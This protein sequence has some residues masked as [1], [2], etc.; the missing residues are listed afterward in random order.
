[1]RRLGAIN[2]FWWFAGLTIFVTLAV[3][4]GLAVLLW[5]EIDTHQKTVILQI[6]KAYFAYIFIAAFFFAAALFI[7]LD[8]FFH[9]YIIPLNKITEQTAIIATVNPS[10]R[11]KL[12]G[13]RDIQRLAEIINLGAERF[14]AMGR[15]TTSRIES[16]KA[17][18]EAEKNILAGFISELPQGVLVCNRKGRILLYNRQARN[19]LMGVDRKK[20]RGSGIDDIPPSKTAGF[21]G[22][23]RSITDILDRNMLAHAQEVL[24]QKLAEPDTPSVTHFLVA[25]QGGMFL[26]AEMAPILDEDEHLNGFILV[27][28]NISAQLE[29]KRQAA[30]Q[31]QKFNTLMRASLAGIRS[32]IET[33]IDYPDLEPGHLARFR[34]IIH[35]EVITMGDHL[36]EYIPKIRP[37][38]LSR[39][40][41]VPVKG[42]YLVAA[43]LQGAQEKF[44][45]RTI[46][47]RCDDSCWV[48]IESY[49]MVFA[50]L[51]VLYRVQQATKSNTYNIV[52]GI[53]EGFV[54]FELIWL[55]RSLKLEALRGWKTDDLTIEQ[56]GL[57]LT[58][59][60][61]L[62]NHGAD[63]WVYRDQ[64]DPPRNHLRFFLPQYSNTQANSNDNNHHSATVLP[65]AM[66]RP[67]FYDF[68][69][70]SQPGQTPELDQCEL[71]E[72]TYTVFD[73]ETTGLNP[74]EGDQIIAIGAIRLV[75]GRL[76]KEELFDQLIDPQR[77]IP[78]ES[79]Q[80]HGITLDMVTG[81]PT[82]DRILPR[83]D[84]FAADTIL[85]AHNAAFDMRMLQMA[86]EKSGI[87]F[88]NPILDTLLLSAI[89]HPAHTSH[90]IGDIARRL[91]VDVIARH[92]AAGDAI[93]TGEIFLKMVPLLADM[94]IM[95]LGEAQAA[96][97]KTYY[98]RLKY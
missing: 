33:I 42:D 69:L 79:A 55:G 28:Q 85:I 36:D 43:V 21:I 1:M 64:L 25:G 54:A 22:L 15:D 58:L 76:L 35:G 27:L 5:Q 7:A 65:P 72:L 74:A 19:M 63:L 44:D 18:L 17:A 38:S 78:P 30:F 12:D 8:A 56:E 4:I 97:R 71:T 73:T 47:E 80:I 53:E 6:F 93:T 11:V 41:L 16:A 94:G 32:A 62:R 20:A 82:I 23:G 68:D 29:S 31:I 66:G 3:V 49:S 46:I 37:R 75:N 2:T 24:E 81:K 39:W 26:N 50:I 48:K 34:E 83:F 70:F 91:G 86:E 77:S 67:E 87:R 84:Q 45:I 14:E 96:A 98:A 60:E 10:L 9:N 89:I 95:T 40:P 88:V 51:Y 59:G 13:S 90:N 92:T 61:V 57:G 52:L